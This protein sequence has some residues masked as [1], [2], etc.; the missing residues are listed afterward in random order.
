[1]VNLRAILQESTVSPEELSLAA[2]ALVVLHL[3]A[4][5]FIV[6]GGLLVFRRPWIAWLHLPAAA[7]GVL[8]EFMGWICPLTPWEQ[9][10]RRAAGEAAYR[11]GF[12]ERYLFPLIYPEHLTRELQWLLG[13]AVLLFNLLVYGAWLVR[14]RRMP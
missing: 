14:R 4:I 10:L 9:A 2:D 12:V 6:F 3:A 7:W 11:G 1:M 13:A 8:L 5:A